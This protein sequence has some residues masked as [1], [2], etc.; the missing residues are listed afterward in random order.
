MKKIVVFLSLIMVF[1]LDIFSDTVLVDVDAGGCKKLAVLSFGSGSWSFDG[2]SDCV[3]Y[4]ERPLA[5]IDSADSSIDT[6]K[7]IKAALGDSVI[8]LKKK[9]YDLFNWI[10]PRS[11]YTEYGAVL[12]DDKV[13]KIKKDFLNEN[14]FPVEC[15]FFF[16]FVLFVSI[17]RMF[18]DDEVST[19][20]SANTLF[21]IF[22]VASVLSFYLFASMFCDNFLMG[23]VFILLLLVS[24]LISVMLSLVVAMIIKDKI[25]SDLETKIL[26][27]VFFA[28]LIAI[29]SIFF[30]IDFFDR[31]S[32]Y[33]HYDFS[34][35]GVYLLCSGLMIFSFV[36]YV[37]PFWFWKKN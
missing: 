16:L 9:H 18:F 6:K 23:I 28:L 17:I 22:S 21:W 27:D 8:L 12:S 30:S 19:S 24:G 33:H 35:L 15:L 3:T 20:I 7:I 29:T 1:C 36:R 34:Y 13:L 10:Y 31:Y 11:Y 32:K 37:L 2:D 26:T 5:I 25:K 4:I 14:L